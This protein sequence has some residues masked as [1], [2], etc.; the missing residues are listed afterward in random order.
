VFSA[1]VQ[2]KRTHRVYGAL[3][4][5]RQATRRLKRCIQK[6]RLVAAVEKYALNLRRA[7]WMRKWFD[8]VHILSWENREAPFLTLAHFAS[9][10]MHFFPV[11]VSL[12]TFGAGHMRAIYRS[13]LKQRLMLL[14]RSTSA[15]LAHHRNWKAQVRAEHKAKKLQIFYEACREHRERQMFKEELLQVLGETWL[16]CVE[17]G[18]CDASDRRQTRCSAKYTVSLILP[19]FACTQDAMRFSERNHF[20][21]RIPNLL[22]QWRHCVIRAQ[23]GQQLHRQVVAYSLSRALRRWKARMVLCRG[24]RQIHQT[25]EARLRRQALVIFA[26]IVCV[27]YLIARSQRS[28]LA[29]ALAEWHQRLSGLE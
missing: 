25:I 27:K 24:V 7:G 5:S 4:F 15:D 13:R 10:L 23:I 19:I 12:A 11:L 1:A 18:A 22:V 17:V 20:T 3:L 14:W 2:R 21:R 16:M 29:L 26:R 28:T 8:I 6:W 9:V